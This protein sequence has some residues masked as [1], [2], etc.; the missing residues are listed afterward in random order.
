MTAETTKKMP[1][2]QPPKLTT[3]FA[4]E[5]AKEERTP[6]EKARILVRLV[7]ALAAIDKKEERTNG[8]D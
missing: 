1:L 8:N 6:E 5:P 3:Q 4:A 2:D 7:I